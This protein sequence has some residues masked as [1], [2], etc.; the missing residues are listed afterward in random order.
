M[1]ILTHDTQGNK[2]SLA[3]TLLSQVDKQSELVASSGAVIG[4]RLEPAVIDSRLT[5]PRAV[6]AR[7]DGQR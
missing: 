5:E 6:R 2:S 3:V 1:A 4:E 7:R